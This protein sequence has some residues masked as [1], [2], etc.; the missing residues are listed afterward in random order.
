MSEITSAQCHCGAVAFNIR[1]VDG[2]HTVRRCNC[3]LCRMRGAVVAIAAEVEV[4]RGKEALTEYRFNSQSVAHYFCSTCGIYTFHQTRSNPEQY[5]VNV[6]CIEGVSPF[7]FSPIN[8]TDGINHPKDGGAGG[9]A[10]TLTYQA[11]VAHKD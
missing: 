6:A 5:G 4:T 7:D 9:V 3:S 10:G 11:R 8:V 1:L 2:Y